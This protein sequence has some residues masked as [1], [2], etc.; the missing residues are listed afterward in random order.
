MKKFFIGV[1]LSVLLAANSVF[2]MTFQQPVE[3]GQ[4][5][6]SQV[7]KGGGGFTF[8]KA[9]KNDG[10]YYTAHH[11]DNT[12]SYGKGVAQF[13]EGAVA[14]Y[15]HY[16]AYE[17]HDVRVGSKD[18]KNTFTV[19]IFSGAIFKID[20]DEGLTLYVVSEGYNPYGGI[21]V[22]GKKK[23]GTFVKYLDTDA[24]NKRYFSLGRYDAYTQRYGFYPKT[25]G[26]TL[27]IEYSTDNSKCI[28]GEF[29]FKWDDNAQWFGVEQVV[30]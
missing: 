8:H 19:P 16:N 5:G 23:D 21:T 6:R 9:F 17:K 7:G 3:L 30:Y 24:I 13:G 27:I 20:T 22:I 15:V 10:D 29:R 2:A 28:V 1:V 14:V 18:I 11:K 4:I 26:D 12:S 25:K